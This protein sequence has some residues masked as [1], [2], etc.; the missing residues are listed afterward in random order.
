MTK[1][2]ASGRGTVV[3]VYFRV[4]AS[5]ARIRYCTG[6]AP[7]ATALSNCRPLTSAIS[8]R[9][10]FFPADKVSRYTRFVSGP[11]VST[12]TET[13]SPCGTDRSAGFGS[14]MEILTRE[15]RSMLA[16]GFSARISRW[17]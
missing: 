5:P 12:R 14:R 17:S 10:L 13:T 8:T 2:F 4:I 6:W 3:S 11:E 1:D 16:S 9:S 15:T 7:T